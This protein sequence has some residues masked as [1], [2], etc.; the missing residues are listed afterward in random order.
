MAVPFK[1]LSQL[2]DTWRGVALMT[3]IL[4]AGVT[5]GVSIGGF[6][7]LPERMTVL[8]ALQRTADSIRLAEKH[9]SD[10][11][12]TDMAVQ[13]TAIRRL[14]RQQLCMS[15]ADRRRSPWEEC[16]IPETLTKPQ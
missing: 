7:K 11:L 16:V 8:E 15:I 6:H 1:L 4:A 12:A 2:S 14:I 13:I 3:A 9:K 10:S 5:I